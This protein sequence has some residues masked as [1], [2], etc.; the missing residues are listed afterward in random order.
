VR[1]QFRMALSMKMTAFSDIAPYSIT[2]VDQHFRGD[3]GGSTHLWNIG[4]LV[5]NY[6][7]QSQKAVIS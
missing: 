5:Q 2:E 3:D 4:Q 1:F 6:M 7:V